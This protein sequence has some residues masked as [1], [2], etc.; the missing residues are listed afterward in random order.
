[1]GKEVVKAK[2]ELSGPKQVGKI[3]LDK[4]KK[5]AEPKPE[6][7]KEEKKEEAKKE[8]PKKEEEKKEEA[9]KAKAK[10]T[11]KEEAKTEPA[12]ETLK[13]Q[14]KKLSGPTIAGEK[15]DLSKFNKPKKKKE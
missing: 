6:A 8:E 9:P 12:D 4:P 2:A 3:D 7:P 10:E 1:M 13:T 15:I 11:P 14:Y 5:E